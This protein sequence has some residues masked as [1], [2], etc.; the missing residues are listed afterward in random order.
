MAINLENYTEKCAKAI[1]NSVELAQDKKNSQVEPA[2]LFYALLNQEKTAF[3][4]LLNTQG[5]DLETLK[6]EVKE[7]M[8]KAP[9]LQ[10]TSNTPSLSQELAKILE[11]AQKEMEKLE[12]YYISTEHFLLAF[13]SY[14]SQ[15]SKILKAKN[16]N[17]NSVFNELSNVRGNMNIK[18][19]NPESKYNVLEQYGH[20]FTKEAKEGQLDPVIGRDEEI[21]RVMQ[22]LARRT[23]NNPVLIGDPGVGKT[24]IVEG[25][26]QRIVAGDVPESI[27]NK[28]IIGLEMASLLAGAKYKGEFEERLRSVLDEIKKAEG[29]IILF[30]DELHTIVGAGKTEGA[31]DASNMLKPMLARGVLH[32]IGATTLDEY[33]KNIEKDAALER[34]LQ[35]VYINEPSVN[36]TIA[37]LRGLK[38]KYEIYHGVKVTDRALVQAAKLSERYITDRFLPD[39]AVDLIDEATS[40]LKM[41]IES[42]PAEL[43]RL[44]RK[45]AQLEVEREAI[46][47]EKD[48]ESKEKLKE[49]EKQISDLKEENNALQNAWKKEKELIAKSRELSG[50]IDELKLKQEKV[51][52]EGDYQK[53]AEIKYS[54]IPEIENKINKTKEDLE[55]IPKEKRMLREEVTEEDVTKVISSWTGIPTTRLLKDEAQKLENLEKELKERVVGQDEAISVVARAIRRSRAGLKAK[56]KPIGSFIFLGPTGVGKTELSKAL[57]RLLFDDENVITRFDM[58]EYMERYSVSRLVGAPPGYVGYEEGGQ[59]T[60]PVRRRPYSVILFDEIEKAHPEVFNMLLQILDDGRLTDSQGRVANFS[61]TVII[62]TSNLGSEIISEYSDKNE[63]EMRKKTMEIAKQNFKPE[64]LNRVDNIVVFK[65]LT[66]ESL[67]EIIKIQLADVAQNLREEKNIEIDFGKG[68]EEMLLK[69]GFDIAYGARPLKRA[70]QNKILDE[71]S[72]QIIEEK[73]VEGDKI[74]V[75][76]GKEGEVSF[77]KT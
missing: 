19:Q 5:V 20:D 56:E 62:M 43:D 61:N 53:V 42:K 15:L 12:D 73:I 58:S 68:V 31:M 22:I 28:K 74:K 16:I 2:H 13:L 65:R 70:I 36:D 26:A 72:M 71:L 54:T 9:K 3:P 46:K 6:S 66:E 27:K 41:E 64:F 37:I 1:Q 21:R 45:I 17:Y 44:E 40:T 24:A 57:A 47:G 10:N 60:E 75:K 32:L 4:A 7:I 67:K 48:K 49:L 55:K 33:R 52:R 51:E 77:E 69:E 30:V 18:D 11:K 63:E 38:E 25:L 8:E 29:G 59:L 50:E 34:R 14:D 39:K 76:V 23:K 35:P